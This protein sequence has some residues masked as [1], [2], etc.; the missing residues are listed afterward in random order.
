V[1][2]S[3]KFNLLLKKKKKIDTQNF[4]NILLYNSFL[5]GVNA[6]S[7]YNQRLEEEWKKEEQNPISEAPTISNNFSTSTP[8]QRKKYERTS[9]TILVEYQ[10]IISTVNS[11]QDFIKKV[12]EKKLVEENPETLKKLKNY[13]YNHQKKIVKQ[14]KP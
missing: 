5:E 9:K 11:Q 7:S 6:M 4:E 8:V 13:Y 1:V 2:S 12:L 3:I 14:T 10:A